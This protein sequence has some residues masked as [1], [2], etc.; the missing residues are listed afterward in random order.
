MGSFH[1]Q[2]KMEFETVQANLEYVFFLSTDKTV[3]TDRAN[4]KVNVEQKSRLDSLESY[5]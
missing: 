1:K 2:L 5:E 3:S 4:F